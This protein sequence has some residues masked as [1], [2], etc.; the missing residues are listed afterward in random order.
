MGQ[1][2][3]GDG[4]FFKLVQAQVVQLEVCT[5]LVTVV[6]FEGVNSDVID[7]VFNLEVWRVILDLIDFF[8]FYSILSHKFSC[9]LLISLLL[10]LLL[11][12]PYLLPLSLLNHQLKLLDRILLLEVHLPPLML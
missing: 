3:V 2:V 5:A 4:V 9:L 8:K 1:G 7:D 12:L 6:E 10:P 11:L